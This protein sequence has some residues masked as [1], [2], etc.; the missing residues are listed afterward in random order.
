VAV[1]AAASSM[2]AAA[3]SVAVAVVVVVVRTGYNEFSYVGMR[4]LIF[5]TW[6]IGASW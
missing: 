3:V 2:L 6:L 4:N 1:A 5:G